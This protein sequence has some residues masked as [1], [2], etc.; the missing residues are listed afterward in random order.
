MAIQSFHKLVDSALSNM[1]TASWGFCVLVFDSS[2][3]PVARPGV[4]FV[5]LPGG[6]GNE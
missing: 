5:C 1:K 4:D 3:E 2:K 6:S